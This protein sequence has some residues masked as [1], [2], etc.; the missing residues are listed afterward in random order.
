MANLWT[1]AQVFRR[2]AREHPDR[3]LMVAGGSR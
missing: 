3:T 2:S 1:L